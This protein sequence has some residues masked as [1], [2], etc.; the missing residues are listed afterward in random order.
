L[1]IE[2]LC[3]FAVVVATIAGCAGDEADGAPWLRSNIEDPY[4]L[5]D[6][7][8]VSS[9]PASTIGLSEAH[10]DEFRVYAVDVLRTKVSTA[11]VHDIPERFF[12]IGAYDSDEPVMQRAEFGVTFSASRM[13]SVD[14]TALASADIM[15]LI[16]D[17]QVDTQTSS[18]VI[19]TGPVHTRLIRKG[20]EYCNSFNLTDCWSADEV[21]AFLDEEPYQG[22]PNADFF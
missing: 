14:D 10:D 2:K 8:F 9:C 5:A 20:S 7:S 11:S 17:C 6:L 18:Y 13:F 15:S 16:N 21:Y 4:V 3:L 12:A 19:N 22:E 1:T